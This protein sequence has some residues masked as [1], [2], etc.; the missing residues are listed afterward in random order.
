MR[1][2]SNPIIS[3]ETIA[4]TAPG[5]AEST[6][7]SSTAGIMVPL[8]TVSDGLL[9]R[10]ARTRSSLFCRRRLVL[11][12]G[13]RVLALLCCVRVLYSAG[14]SGSPSKS[15]EP[16]DESTENG[17]DRLPA[18]PSFGVTLSFD[19]VA[20][21]VAVRL[22]SPVFGSFDSVFGC[23]GTSGVASVNRLGRAICGGAAMWSRLIDAGIVTD[24]MA[25]DIRLASSAWNRRTPPITSNT[26][27]AQKP[28]L[29]PLAVLTIGWMPSGGR[30]S[31]GV[32]VGISFSSVGVLQR[33]S[34]R[35]CGIQAWDKHDRLRRDH[36][37]YNRQQFLL[38]QS[39]RS[40]TPRATPG[41]DTSL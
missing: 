11:L 18:A 30:G 24:G 28:K 40:R 36:S 19:T 5:L 6:A 7:L 37:A 16:L 23:G 10:V 17:I 39:G 1:V 29:P 2:P 33:L 25:A 38:H 8:G 32:F 14:A 13:T 20:V 35:Q 34:R 41:W 22:L 26:R 21:R 9:S 15:F 4:R 3:R 31:R 12:C 27:K